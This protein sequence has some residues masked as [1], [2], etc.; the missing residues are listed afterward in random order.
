M[1]NKNVTIFHHNDID[2][3]MSNA[4]VRYYEKEC[5]LNTT[6]SYSVNYGDS[7][8]C[9]EKVGDNDIVYI[10]DYSFTENTV[11]QLLEI[12]NIAEKVIWIDHHASSKELIKK[13]DLSNSNIIPHINTEYSGA[14]LCYAILILG[15]DINTIKD[16][17]NDMP[18]FIRYV[19]DWDTW[20]HKLNH[21]KSFKYGCSIFKWDGNS[22]DDIFYM[23]MSEVVNTKTGNYTERDVCAN[24]KGTNNKFFNTLDWE[25]EPL[26]K[27]IITVGYYISMY[28]KNCII[29]M[30]T[31]SQYDGYIDVVGRGEA[32]C[33]VINSQIH[34]SLIFNPRPEHEYEIV[35]HYKSGKYIYS[36]YKNTIA[37]NV[38]DLIPCDIIALTYGGGGHPGAAGFTSDEY[39][40]EERIDPL[41]DLPMKHFRMKKKYR[42]L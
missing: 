25:N 41:Q 9:I 31:R 26:L 40:I 35:W 5:N 1:E 11:N 27:N 14:M 33:A 12:A 29:P 16:N 4:I 39:I 28:D 2:G 30:N 21:T 7:V 8:P 18:D 36:I 37:P 3:Y 38:D 34:S 42:T 15:I 24:T 17:E 20:K 32:L 10:V 23:L 22:D 19:D 6:K 13:L